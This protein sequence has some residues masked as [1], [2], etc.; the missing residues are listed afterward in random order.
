MPGE[1]TSGQI[2]NAAI[3]A[4]DLA[5][6]PGTDLGRCATGHIRVAVN[7]IDTDT[8]TITVNA[9]PVI[10]EFDNNATIT[11]GNIAVTLGGGAA[12]SATNLRAAI[13][14]NQ[15]AILASAVHTVDTTDIDLRV[16]AAGQ[17]FALAESTA[18]ARLVVQDNGEELA[19]TSRV[20]YAINRTVT[21]EDVLR[22][23]IVVRTP[24][25]N[26]RA[27]IARFRTAANNFTDIAY[28]GTVT[29]TGGTIEFDFDGITDPAA[30]NILDLIV[31]GD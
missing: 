21:A 29:I 12:A 10:Y 6:S 26:I 8:V 16:I 24:L 19:A 14:A 2:L 9:V 22:D 4:A 31:W 18:A 20:V 28:N 5:F 23:R 1:I 13:V 15:G 17:A 7:A 11:P 27:W 25:T 3:V 30:A